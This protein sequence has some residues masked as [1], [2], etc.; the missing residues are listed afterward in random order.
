[1]E[2]PDCYWAG[3]GLYLWEENLR[4]AA[5]RGLLALGPLTSARATEDID[6]FLLA[7]VTA[8]KDEVSR[9]RAAMEEPGFMVVPG[10][11]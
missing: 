8:S 9:Y 4:I 5:A 11:E 7:E 2:A 6:L 1:M 10:S 3:L